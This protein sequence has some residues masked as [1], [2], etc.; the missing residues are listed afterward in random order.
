LREIVKHATHVNLTHHAQHVNIGNMNYIN[1]VPIN[2]PHGYSG[3]QEVSIMSLGKKIKQLRQEKG[4][5]QDELA[6]HAQIDG[7]QVSR[8]ENDKVTPSVEVVVK[9][10]KAFDVSA[11]HLLF[12]DAP[13]RAM[14]EPVGKLAE[15]I[16]HLE[17]LSDADE[18]SLLHVLSAIEAK[19]KLKTLMESIK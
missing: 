4:W 16:M 2:R 18:A 3:D 7:R 15:K 5:S 19:N 9:L 10:A 6:Y 13:K 11:D 8:Y 1:S 14:Q 17:N 12:D